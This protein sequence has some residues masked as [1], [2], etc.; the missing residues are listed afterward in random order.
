MN[1]IERLRAK[2]Y[3]AKGLRAVRGMLVEQLWKA[4]AADG[5][6]VRAAILVGGTPDELAQEAFDKAAALDAQFGKPNPE[7]LRAVAV[8]A[9]AAAAKAEGEER[10]R[11]ER[12][13]RR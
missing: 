7:A 11:V 6:N 8:W 2:G 10:A 4:V 5:G 13:A 12:A 1:W 9:L 3:T